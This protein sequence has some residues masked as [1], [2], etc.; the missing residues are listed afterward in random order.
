MR[1]LEFFYKRI[2]P[3]LDADNGLTSQLSPQSNQDDSCRK[4]LVGAAI[5]AAVG[6]VEEKGWGALSGLAIGAAAGYVDSKT[7]S[8]LSNGASTA[9]NF[10]L[11]LLRGKN[12][13]G[14][15]GASVPG[16]LVERLT[17][18][19]NGNAVSNALGQGTA[20]SVESYLL[21]E[22]LLAASQRFAKDAAAA[23]GGYFFGNFLADVFCPAKH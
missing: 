15:L 1:E 20:G 12:P 23:T 21:G 7:N 16:Y 13:F 5:G 19:D 4:T 10:E 11:M 22:G 9:L 8:L 17:G 2:T 6:G 18:G 14:G 3:T